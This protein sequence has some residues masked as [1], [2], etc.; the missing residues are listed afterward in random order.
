MIA[1]PEVRR[2]D[3]EAARI[4]TAVLALSLPTRGA[5]QRDAGSASEP[6][7]RQGLVVGDRKWRVP[8]GP[9]DR[10]EAVHKSIMTE[11]GRTRRI[12][13]LW[14]PPDL[15]PGATGRRCASDEVWVRVHTQTEFH[16]GTVGGK[17]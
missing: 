8:R 5:L 2:E 10:R 16:R 13:E 1:L 9:N 15:P 14:A 7:L 4:V 17:S 12:V 3:A 6:H 11:S